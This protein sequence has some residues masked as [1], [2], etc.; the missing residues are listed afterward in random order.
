MTQAWDGRIERRNNAGDHDN[1]TRLITILDNHVKNFD[2]HVE[3]DE[4]RFKEIGDKLW[5]HAKFI[6]IGIGI[7]AVLEVFIRK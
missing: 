3:K 4:A 5:N 6:Y 2:Q 7:V 1:I